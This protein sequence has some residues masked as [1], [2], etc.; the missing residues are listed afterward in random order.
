MGFGFRCGFLGLLHMEI[1]NERFSREYYL[2]L[3]MM[4]PSV[5]YK[6]IKGDGK[7]AMIYSP[8]K[9]PDIMQDESTWEPYVKMDIL[10]PS[11]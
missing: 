11:E 5:T 1:I 4:V 10:I 8:S 6:I 3:I 9:M 2:D 7:E